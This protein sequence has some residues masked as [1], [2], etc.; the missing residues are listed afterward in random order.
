MNEVN[1]NISNCEWLLQQAEELNAL[2]SYNSDAM[3]I[4][5]Q[6]RALSAVETAITALHELKAGIESIVGTP[7]PDAVPT[8]LS[9]EYWVRLHYGWEEHPDD[10]VYHTFE[11]SDLAHNYDARA[12]E[13]KLYEAL[14]PDDNGDINFNWNTMPVKLPKTLVAKIQADA[15]SA[16]TERI[17]QELEKRIASNEDNY[18]SSAAVGYDGG[19]TD[20]CHDAYVEA[21]DLLGIEHEHEMRN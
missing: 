13:K 2:F 9:E 18:V 8:Q 4:S 21:L 12:I 5:N 3:I 7:A 14:A 20:G 17:G 15:I 11:T 19:Y 16:H 6:V 1:K 10:G